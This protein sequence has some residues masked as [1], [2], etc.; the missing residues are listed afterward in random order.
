M[1][2]SFTVFALALSSLLLGAGCESSVE[3]IRVAAGCPQ[4]PLRGPLAFQGEP[5]N[6]LIDDFESG[7]EN[8][9]DV[10]GRVGS[11][12]IG[13]DKAS[14]RITSEASD[15][16]AAR[17]RYA[18]HFAS[19]GFGR[20]GANWT[21]VF[22]NV[23]N[24]PAAPYDAS[25]YNA[26]S[27]WGAFGANNGPDFEVA[28]GVTTMDNAWNSHLCQVCMDYYK[29]TAALSH[30]WRRFVLP[31]ASMAQDGHGSPLVPMRKDQMVGF[32]IWPTQQFDIWIDDVR[33]EP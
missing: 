1:L 9:A 7:N 16:C 22:V 12:V 8:L 4:Q 14:G 28:L 26:I 2:R 3:P 25:K 27:F 32:I 30:E 5:V 11:W 23:P 29:T 18:G 6:Q 17:G 13:D 24:A 19:Q 15:Q 31:F 10:D 21:A 20:W 33:F